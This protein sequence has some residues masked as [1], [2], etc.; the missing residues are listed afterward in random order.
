MSN[1]WPRMVCIVGTLSVFLMLLMTVELAW[2]SP[3]VS[4]SAFPP[5]EEE[6]PPGLQVRLSEVPGPNPANRHSEKPK[7]LV[8]QWLS[9]TQAGLIFKRL[10]G[11]QLISTDVVPFRLPPKTLPLPKT[12]DTLARVFPSSESGA[13]PGPPRSTGP[14]RVMRYQ[15][16]GPIDEAKPISVT[17]SHPMLAAQNRQDLDQTPVPV[18]ISPP[19]EGQ[20]QWSSPVTAVFTPVR[21][22]KATQFEVTV[23]A[24]TQSATGNALKDTRQWRF[25][26]P[27]PHIEWHFVGVQDDVLRPLVVIRFDQKINPDEVAPFLRLTVQGETFPIQKV[28]FAEL[29]ADEKS[30]KWVLDYPDEYFVFFKPVQLLPRNS[31]VTVTAL[32]SLPSAEGPLTALIDQS[33]EFDTY[34]LLRMVGD[35]ST[36][37]SLHGR[38]VLEFNNQLDFKTFRPEMVTISPPIPSAQ[39][40][41]WQNQILIDGKKPYVPVYTVTVSGDL[42]DQSGQRLEQPVSRQFKIRL[43]QPDIHFD[44]GVITTFDPGGLHQLN[45]YSQNIQTL[46][47]RLYR[48][49][50]D[51]WNAYAS[52]GVYGWAKTNE[53][54]KEILRN[55]I[56]SQSIPIKVELDEAIKRQIDLTPALPNGTGQILVEVSGDVA[57]GD[58]DIHTVRAFHWVQS[59]KLA[60]DVVAGGSE[61]LVWANSLSDGKPVS[62]ATVTAYP[63]EKT[64]TVDADGL[65]RIPFQA[66]R[67]EYNHLVVRKGEDSA[68]LCQTYERWSCQPPGISAIHWHLLSDRTLYQPGEDIHLKG[69][70]RVFKTNQTEPIEPAGNAFQSVSYTITDPRGVTLGEGSVPVNAFGGFYVKGQI[71]KTAATGAASIHLSA[72]LPDTSSLFTGQ[73]TQHPFQIEEYQRPDFEVTVSN[74]DGPFVIGGATTATARVQ[75]YTGGSL[76]E[77]PVDWT[78]ITEPARFTPPNWGAF[79]FNEW[80]PWWYECYPQS[81]RIRTSHHSGKTNASGEHHLNLDFLSLDQIQPFVVKTEASVQDINRREVSAHSQFL[82][83]PASVYV[84]L[85]ATNCFGNIREPQVIKAIVTDLDGTPIAGQNITFTVKLRYRYHTQRRR[86]QEFPAETI[87]S[88]DTPV[89]WAFTP[90]ESGIYQVTAQIRDAQGRL[91][92]TSVIAWA[93]DDTSWGPSTLNRQSVTLI[94]EKPV[95]EVGEVAE[96]LVQS[97]F[98]PA[99]GLVT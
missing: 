42:T 60:V 12:D 28:N 41:V 87:K 99:E 31:V 26:T 22:P 62:G 46:N 16:E 1:Q 49:T 5:Q 54:T 89:P 67:L 96:I 83:H 71:P 85:Q 29:E 65:G 79:S 53:V 56:F 69:W 73:D 86:P 82:V 44:Y 50:A 80:V 30:Q 58:F 40:T 84:G 36:E 90:Q 25:S 95:Y 43:A 64:V 59:S 77:V 51:D 20:W 57:P 13:T 52:P 91:S 23:P 7:P 68:L 98:A 37:S 39:I 10:P 81:R 11:L 75:Y 88:A 92:Q 76:S 3:P 9:G 2:P 17:F 6:I 70:A 47:V 33:F 61:L 94:P 8:T 66:D 48:V 14:L 32:T 4:A 63:G 21:L 38:M 72:D 55:P 78:V 24:G 97:P 15:P 35:E 45:V 27:G 19:I 74:G 18:Q 93:I 34:P